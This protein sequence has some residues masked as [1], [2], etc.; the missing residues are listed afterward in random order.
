MHFETSFGTNR[1]HSSY[2][3]S[4]LGSCRNPAVPGMLCGFCSIDCGLGIGISTCQGA[5]MFVHFVEAPETTVRAEGRYKDI[6]PVLDLQYIKCI[7]PKS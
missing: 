3:F 7:S 4:W 1:D 6:V 5:R 2:A